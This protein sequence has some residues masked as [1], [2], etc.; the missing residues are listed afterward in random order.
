MKNMDT[1]VVIHALYIGLSGLANENILWVILTL[2]MYIYCLL[3]KSHCTAPQ[4]FIREL[5]KISE[6]SRRMESHPEGTLLE[7]K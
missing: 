5:Y 2:K 6:I 7:V 1:V 4:Y 3:K